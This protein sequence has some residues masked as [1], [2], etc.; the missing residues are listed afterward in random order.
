MENLGEAT[1]SPIRALVR[2]R[3]KLIYA[4]GQP[5][6]LHD[7]RADPLEW[8]NLAGPAGAPSDAALAGAEGSSPGRLG[9][10]AGRRGGAPQPAPRAFLKEALFAGRYAPLGLRASERG[11]E[12]YVRRGSNWQWDPDLGV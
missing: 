1:I 11:A 6:E 7:L 4:H 10:G 3:H 2:G 5:D 12:A 9:P 8:T